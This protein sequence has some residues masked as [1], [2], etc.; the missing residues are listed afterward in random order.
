MRLEF[1][2][3]NGKRYIRIVKSIRVEKNGKKVVRKKTIQNIGPVSR[4]DDGLPD[5]ESRLKESFL[6]CNP[7]IPELLP[8]LPKEQSLERYVFRITEGSQECIGHPKIFSQ[9]LLESILEEIDII[10]VIQSYKGFSKIKFD[11]LGYL[12]LLVYG[13]ILNPASKIATV[14]QNEDYFDPI[15]SDIYDYHVYDTLDFIYEHKKQIFNRMN[16][17][18]SKKFG[19]KSD[20]IYYDVTNFYFETEEADDD[21]TDENGVV[22]SKGIRKMGV[23]KE[24]RKQ[25]IVQ[26]GLFMDNSGYPISYEIFPG[27]T[28]DHL[29]VRDSL[30]NTV[31]NMDF[32]RFIFVGDRGMCSYVNLLHILSLGN[33]YVVS[34]SI[35]K[36]KDEE[37]AWIYDNTGYTEV[38]PNFKYKSRVVTKKVKDENGVLHTISEKVVVYWDKYFYDRQMHENKSFLEFLEKLIENPNGFRVSSSQ[39]KSIRK[40]LKSEYVNLDSGELLDSSKLRSMIDTDKVDEFKKEMGY[41]Q[42]VTS[43]LNRAETDIIDVYHGLSRI[44]DQF[45]VLK[46]DLSTRPIFVNTKEHIDAHLAICTIALTVMRII[47]SK[48]A[49]FTDTGSNGSGWSYGISADRVRSALNA[50]TIENIADEYYRFN[51]IDHSD[52]KLIFDAFSIKIPTKL[53]KKQE[54]KSLRSSFQITS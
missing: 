20:I 52:L 47:Q 13:R 4:F 53:F 31:D 19:R 8:Y 2:D 24:N 9:Y 23:S 30:K 5:F 14:R 17:V 51:N 11:L 50:W 38:S 42:I 15:V 36:S 32:G 28:L 21:I 25:P 37:K 44:E 40:F 48:V 33:G 39:S 41:Y 29:T 27:N 46:G 18:M 3:N 26:M 35:A 22:I 16:A 12:R 49:S 7:L 10:Q 45:R 1:S 6:S 54:L 34:K 43:E